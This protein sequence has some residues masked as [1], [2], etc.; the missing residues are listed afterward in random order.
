MGF[1]FSVFSVCGESNM[2]RKQILKG[3][4]FVIISAVIFG[5]NAL[6]VT[7][8]YAQGINA[9][10]LVF[11]RSCLSAPILGL[12]ARWKHGTLRIPAAAVPKIGL[13]GIMGCCLTPVLL[14]SSY[15]Y[16]ASGTATVFHF[17]Y[18]ATVVIGEILF[19]RHKVKLGNLISVALCVFGI[20]LFFDPDAKLNFAGSAF[21]LIS[22]VT[23]TIYILLLSN[24]RFPS[25][26]GFLLSFYISIVSGVVMLC[27]CLA[28]G[29]LT[30]PVSF[31][32][33][34][35]CFL[36]ALVVNIG[37]F[38]LFQ[39]GTLLVGG[40]QASILSTLEPIVSMIVGVL[41]FGETAGLRT[42]AG[43][44]LVI[45]ASILIALTGMK[46]TK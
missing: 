10:S 18:P 26:S 23:Y 2:E 39:E 21:A 41:V 30:L 44:F 9:M 29:M 3:Y 17:I 11:M 36:F 45:A 40:A 34:V 4:I 22:G 16:I 43:A 25:V 27:V 13:M 35:S 15:R 42:L 5:C 14:F 6:M 7:S 8:I 32:G 20:L 31:I 37:A 19:L 46:H 12:L 28:S 24:F 38:V 33:W 1:S